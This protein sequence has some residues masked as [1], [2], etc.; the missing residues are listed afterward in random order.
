MTN[1]MEDENVV[2]MG[3]DAAGLEDEEEKEEKPEE[4]PDAYMDNL[5][6]R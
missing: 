4:D 5:E 6:D 2:N 3:D 1:N